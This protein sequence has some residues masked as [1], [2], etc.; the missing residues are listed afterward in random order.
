MKNKNNA[1]VDLIAQRVK[2]VLLTTCFLVALAFIG[3]GTSFNLIPAA[4]AATLENPS[5]VVALGSSATKEVEQQAK[6]ILDEGAG[7]G[8]ADKVQGRLNEAMGKTE[9]NL[10]KV[11]SQTEGTLKEVQGKAQQNLGEAKNRTESAGS[12][13][14]DAGENALDAIKDFFGQ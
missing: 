9:R 1:L 5:F 13:L 10:D 14:E 12:D 2:Q 7:A 3:T 6:G 4:N 11:T 8:T